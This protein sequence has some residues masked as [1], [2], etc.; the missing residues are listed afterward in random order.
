MIHVE[1]Y[2]CLQNYI[3]A[4]LKGTIH[5]ILQFR[6]D[7]HL[8][9]ICILQYNNDLLQEDALIQTAKCMDIKLKGLSVHSINMHI[10]K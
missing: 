9:N 6:F 1:I 8:I 7:L 5:F 4:Q 2:C 10:N 3:H